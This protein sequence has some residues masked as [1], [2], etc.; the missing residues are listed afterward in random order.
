MPFVP[1]KDR[2]HDDTLTYGEHVRHMKKVHG[3]YDRA[4]AEVERL[5]T[6]EATATELQGQLSTM[7]DTAKMTKRLERAEKA[8]LEWEEKHT[9]FVAEATSTAALLTAG[10]TDVDDQKLVRW[11]FTESGEEDLSKFLEGTAKSHKHLAA[12]FAESPDAPA[13]PPQGAPQGKAPPPKANGG[14][15]PPRPPALQVTY[16]ELVKDKD[17]AWWAD[18]ANRAA[19]AKAN[20][21][22]SNAYDKPGSS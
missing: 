10:V 20:G 5:K 2:P 6:F 19:V 7:P 21:L 9:L 11:A 22:P 15:Q 16:T 4:S 12:L 17:R 18:P 1:D 13:T 8:A 14:I 3:D